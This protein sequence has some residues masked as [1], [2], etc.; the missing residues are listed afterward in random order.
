M[1]NDAV[2]SETLE[3]M[4]A[5]ERRARHEAEELLESKSA[6]LFTAN[7]HLV[8]REQYA[9]AIVRS[10]QDGILVVDAQGDVETAN[11]IAEE[12]LGVTEGKLIN[13]SLADIIRVIDGDRT[14][15][16]TSV[17][18]Y[19]TTHQRPVEV[20]GIRADRTIVP[21]R[22][23]AG[24][25]TIERERKLI[26]VLHDLREERAAAS[27]LRRTAF[28]DMLT[29]LGNRA[30]LIDRYE[31][32]T[33]PDLDANFA[34]VAIDLR[35][36]HR[37]NNALGRAMGDLVIRE[38]ALRLRD[39]ARLVQEQDSTYFEYSISRVGGDEFAV[40]LRGATITAD[41]REEISNM[42]AA[43]SQPL[44]LGGET[45][46]L[47]TVA[48]YCLGAERDGD[49]NGVLD[50]ALVAL[51]YA[52]VQTIDGA[53]EFDES[54]SKHSSQVMAM[55]TRIHRGLLD[56]EF[57]VFY[58][59]RVDLA[60]GLINGG[61]ALIRW[62]HPELGVR[63]PSEFI[64]VAE[65]SNLIV[66]IWEFVLEQALELQQRAIEAK[67][68]QPVSINV[69]HIEFSMINLVDRL[70]SVVDAA[71]VRPEFI[72]IELKESVVTQ[73]IGLSVKILSELS[74]LGFS[75]AMD[76]FGTGESSL[77]RLR[78]LNIDVL[79]LDKLFM[80]NLQDDDQAVRILE[81][82]ITLG[83]AIGANVVVEGVE[84]LDQLQTLREIGNCSIQ[85]FV[86]SP[87]VPTET[88]L[89]LLRDQPWRIDQ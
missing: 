81:A 13:A 58:Q 48:G 12:L 21:L 47:E 59:P 24:W 43:I 76:D 28:L 26:L 6:E 46:P 74:A 34:V 68:V 4:L 5:R 79:K 30:A 75:I 80:R 84:N 72:E 14:V 31:T 56:G 57:E 29:G 3:R 78:E 51:E 85:G 54:M 1:P 32:R 87:A 23:T 18:S 25:A 44:V 15:D 17:L 77:G 82:M 49:V 67:T 88:Y 64:H 60:T 20:G 50:R 63:L 89:Q 53:H 8:E 19:F 71:H 35:R 52:S 7:E 45:I 39:R 62:N 66:R 22:A 61:E 73:D 65:Q 9:T 2:S 37:V 69:S 10:A 36:F 16:D 86:F 27:A 33:A 42:R 41:V 83:T 40:L 11:P 38:V 55:E 70:T